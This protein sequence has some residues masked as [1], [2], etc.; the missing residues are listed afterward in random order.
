LKYVFNDTRIFKLIDDCNFEQRLGLCNRSNYQVR[1]VWTASD[2]T[3]LNKI[4]EFTFRISNL[5]VSLFGAI[6]NLLVIIVILQK[7]NKDI[8]YGF[9]QY[10]Y[11]WLNSAFSL[12]ILLIQLFS[13]FS[14]CFWPYQL[15]C[16]RTHQFVF[17]QYF[18]IVF[19]VMLINALRFMC[20][21]TYLMFAVNRIAVL[22]KGQN[23]TFEKISKWGVRKFLAITFSISLLLSSTKYFNYVVN[24]DHPEADYPIR[25]KISV[26]ISFDYNQMD[27]I[28]KVI[29]LLSSLSDLLNHFVFT[30]VNLFVDVV[31]LVK[32]RRTLAEKLAKLSSMNLSR[33]IVEKRKEENRESMNR[34]V[35]M[36]VINSLISILLKLPLMILPV[37]NIAAQFYYLDQ[38]TFM[39][40]N[41]F[42]KTNYGFAAYLN[43][44]FGYFFY[45]FKTSA[46]PDFI[47][48]VGNFCFSLSLSLSFFVYFNFDKNIYHGF[49]RIF[50]KKKVVEKLNTQN[51][52]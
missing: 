21:F 37:I 8:F 3:G 39:F 12:T 31:M 4:L 26:S 49:N 17:F 18:K 40:E 11:L 13:W 1:D 2:Y 27:T 29:F 36:V 35:R 34:A 44:S 46:F 48:S 23:E 42:E 47:D 50:I 9:K 20:N 45:L 28:F 32:L 51:A 15:F 52:K 16:L 6:S 43:R 7:T 5:F 10:V 24:F 14:E 30:C 33:K 38:R 41:F 19:Q 22:V 25:E